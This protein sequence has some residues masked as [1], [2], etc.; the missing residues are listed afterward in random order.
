MECDYGLGM[1]L[2]AV[3]GEHCVSD[4]CW[5]PAC[6]SSLLYFVPYR[7]DS[8]PMPH[9]P[10][11][12]PSTS[13]PLILQSSKC[14]HHPQLLWLLRIQQKQVSVAACLR[15]I[16]S[17]RWCA[18]VRKSSNGR[19]RENRVDACMQLAKELRIQESG[20]KGR[21]HLVQYTG[22]GSCT[23]LTLPFHL[24]DDDD[25]GH[26]YGSCE[27]DYYGN[28]NTHTHWCSHAT[29]VTTTPTIQRY[30]KKKKRHQVINERIARSL[31]HRSL[32]HVTVAL[33][34]RN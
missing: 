29:T 14:I 19:R 31:A 6:C 26:C 23:T 15:V 18:D 12:P 4:W 16:I 8:F 28:H 25:D 17:E 10:S 32:V 2:E 1:Q 24:H 33:S 30:Y 11:I 9:D 7:I 21:W 20:Q 13:I 5:L 22:G 27:Y 34:V 3:G